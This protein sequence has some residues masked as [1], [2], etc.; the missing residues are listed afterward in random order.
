MGSSSVSCGLTGVTMSNQPAVLIPLAPAP[1]VDG[2]RNYPSPMGARIGGNNGACALFGPLTM[3]IMGRVGDVGDFEPDDNEHFQVLTRR[4]Q[5]DIDDFFQGV[6]Y[7]GSH[8]RISRIAR[9]IARDERGNYRKST[10]WD[11]NLRGMWVH[12]EAW[13]EFSTHSWGED[14]K[15]DTS[16]YDSGWL[17][18]HNLAGAGFTKGEKDE[19][20]ATTIL[21]NGVHDGPRY[22][23]PYT[24]PDLPGLIIWCDDHMSSEASF[25]GKKVAVKYHFQQLFETI[26][27]LGLT[28]PPAM[29][30]W[31]RSTSTYW[32]EI[33]K[34]KATVQEA[35]EMQRMTWESKVRNPQHFFRLIRDTTPEDAVKAWR[36][37][38]QKLVRKSLDG[39]QAE[40]SVLEDVP[41]GVEQVFC[42]H[43][44]HVT[45]RGPHADKEATEFGI[46]RCDCGHKPLEL[47]GFNARFSF[48]RTPGL[49][50]S[51]KTEGW[52]IP[53]P[54]RRV[55]YLPGSYLSG[56]P[57]EMLYLYGR[58]LFHPAVTPLME[59]MFMFLT[60]TYAGN[61]ILMPSASGWQCGNFP[62]QRRISLFAA[63][64]AARRGR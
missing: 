34:A 39:G 64:L 57:K 50:D 23:V 35:R 9:I 1:W 53:K 14:G 21:G 42:D 55:P 24:H 44:F 41:G 12:R 11:G 25:N 62:V 28:V 40:P 47:H 63:R 56:F 33:Q 32:T 31:A 17:S 59:R 6:C 10:T 30:T 46:V 18:P 45:L 37:D 48:D 61:R 7:G 52:T 26:R 51:L 54:K 27:K 15:S 16:I 36:R 19:A 5:G 58:D 13:E 43:R 60:N 2:N 49:W 22:N 29:E 8:P 38:T 3:P 20:T 4:L